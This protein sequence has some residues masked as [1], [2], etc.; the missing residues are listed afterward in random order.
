M[1]IRF[2]YKWVNAAKSHDRL[3]QETMAE[4]RIEMGSH[5]VTSVID[6]RSHTYRKHVVVPL[7]SVAEWLVS[8]WHHLFYEWEDA[9]GQDSS[10]TERHDLAHASDGFIL[11]SLTIYPVGAE[12]GLVWNDRNPDHTS[13]QFIDSGSTRM[14]AE[15][16]CAE[17]TR[18][19][20]AVLERAAGVPESARL[21][22]TWAAIQGL[23]QEELEFTRAAALL[24]IDPFDVDEEL[25]EA[26]VRFWNDN[27]QHLREDALA[28]ADEDTLPQVQQWMNRGLRTLEAFDK[29][30]EWNSVRDE[31]TVERGP[32]A[33]LEGYRLARS[34]RDALEAGD[35]PYS[36]E[37][38]GP[39]AL[40]H[41]QLDTPSRRI[42]ALVASDAPACIT[43]PRGE[44][45]TRFLLARALGDYLARDGAR[46]AILSSL[47]TDRQSRSRAFAA[48]FLAPASGLRKRIRNE[49]LEPEDVDELGMEFG[50]SSQVIE[51]QVKNHELGSI[52][53]AASAP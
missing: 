35:D 33:W 3:S 2:G 29:P 24:G 13:L 11:P 20:K 45:G 44:A 1:N 32:R 52:R 43:S 6:H 10:V 42:E 21:R 47:A 25:S 40:L 53:Y 31:L 5:V 26:L 12:V 14:S 34:A 41:E 46:A 38:K 39:L 48:E 18:L 28:L 4:F 27:D 49:V 51:H 50:V 19:I 7:F 37:T 23:N 16:L 17:L 8:N 22:D 15:T 36:F 30:L 9:A